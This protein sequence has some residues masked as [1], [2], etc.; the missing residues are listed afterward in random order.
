MEVFLRDK[1]R[2]VVL[3]TV[4]NGEKASYTAIATD[5]DSESFNVLSRGID[6]LNPDNTAYAEDGGPW[7]LM[8]RGDFKH[9]LEW[10][11]GL[12]IDMEHDFGSLEFGKR[13]AW[14]TASG[15]MVPVE[16]EL[17]E[18]ARHAFDPVEEYHDECKVCKDGVL[19]E[20]HSDVNGETL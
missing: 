7:T 5:W 8:W 19:A 10:V 4:W 12:M 15:R 13:Y 3:H 17:P 14:D 6:V 2:I 1:D 20:C 11:E 18:G 16:D 9:C